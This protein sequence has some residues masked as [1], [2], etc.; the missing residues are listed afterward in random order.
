MPLK[1]KACSVRANWIFT[2]FIFILFGH[3]LP[4]K[5]PQK[6]F[7]YLNTIAADELKAHL[8][9]IA[10]DEMQGRKVGSAFEKLT[11]MYLASQ[12]E[13][14]GLRPFKPGGHDLTDYFQVF[15]LPARAKAK[16]SQN[17]VAYLEGSDAMLKKEVIA[18]T[19][20]YDHLGIG[21]VVNGDSIY[22][23]AADDGSGTVALVEI[24]Q[25]LK[26]A[27]AS[28]VKFKRSFLFINMGGEESGLLGSHFFACSQPLLPLEN[29]RAVINLD[30]VGGTDKPED[31]EANNY[32]YVLA[33]DS[34]SSWLRA[35]A[36]DINHKAHINLAIQQPA[37]P[38]RFMSDNKPFEYELISSIYFST[39]LVEHYHQPS[40]EVTSINFS[41]ME[42]VVR[43]I[44]AVAME[45]A[46]SDQAF[47]YRSAFTKT[48]KYFCPPCGCNSDKKNFDAPGTCPDCTMQLQPRW[49]NK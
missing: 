25:A 35:I 4:A 12:Y 29:I 31:I 20:H 19:A 3:S 14:I 15:D 41:H 24:A 33:P 49:R 16:S 23:G 27:V 10:S 28:G 36:N 13:A 18:I 9:F 47:S 17:V 43:L 22:N 48:G 8:S 2:L 34:T 5:H 42:K 32:V 7:K 38:A 44:C 46:N 11:A 26:T 21:K 1:S 37:N 45:A 39:G 6:Y 40:D 30:G